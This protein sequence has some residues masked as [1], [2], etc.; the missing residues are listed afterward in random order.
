MIPIIFAGLGWF[1][2]GVAL[3]LALDEEGDGLRRMA[4]LS[5]DGLTEVRDCWR[6]ERESERV[7]IGGR[8]LVDCE[9]MA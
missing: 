7:C 2:I 9:K 3:V 6:N 8:I 1:I 5:M 4:Y